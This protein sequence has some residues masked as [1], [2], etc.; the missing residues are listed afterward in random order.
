MRFYE[1]IMHMKD[2]TLRLVGW[3]LHMSNWDTF[4][5]CTSPASPAKYN[6]KNAKVNYTLEDSAASIFWAEMLI[7]VYQT[8]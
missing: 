5:L 7:P 6:K 2:S 4:L 3:A 8:Q 1:H